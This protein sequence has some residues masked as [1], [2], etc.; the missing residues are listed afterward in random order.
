MTSN[1]LLQSLI[2]KAGKDGL[3]SDELQLLKILAE[4]RHKDAEL[5]A[6]IQ[7]KK[8]QRLAEWSRWLIGGIGIGI[9]TWATM[10][11]EEN[12]VVTG[13]KSKILGRIVDKTIN[14]HY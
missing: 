6:D 3:S 13:T 9:I 5:E 11:Y 1:E 7:E 10:Y 4:E 14:R 2:D 8:C 12:G